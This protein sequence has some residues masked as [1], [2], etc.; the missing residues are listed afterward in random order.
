MPP[1]HRQP[2]TRADAR[3]NRE[4][5]L[6]AASEAFAEDGAAVSMDAIARRAGVGSG[7]LYRHFPTLEDLVEEVYRDQ[8]QRLRAGADE[9]LAKEPPARA[10]SMWMVLFADWATTKFG[11]RETLGTIMAAGRLVPSQMRDDLVEILHAF[12]DAGS[13]AG[14]LRADVKAADLGA[15]LAGVLLVA[16][17]PETR[18]QLERML[19]VIVDGLL[20]R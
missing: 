19:A 13:R 11:M 20:P 5:L 12:L 18:P 6:A 15:I 4:R 1:I 16:G 8:L 10:L 2:K 17:A 14:E 9:L 3:R 7:T